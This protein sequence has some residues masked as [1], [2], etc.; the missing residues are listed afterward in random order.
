MTSKHNRTPKPTSDMPTTPF[1]STEEAWFWF[2]QAQQAR[3]DGARF[4]AGVGLIPRPCEPIDIYKVLDRLHRQRRLMMDHLLVLRHYGRRM[5]PPD[6][7]RVKEVRSFK[8]WKEA[9]DRMEPLLVRKGIV[10]AKK[11]STSCPNRFWAHGAIVYEG[12]LHG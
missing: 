9:L 6:P 11:F 7:R 5:M 12:G 4:A 10:R 3:E 2:L 8:L 1:E